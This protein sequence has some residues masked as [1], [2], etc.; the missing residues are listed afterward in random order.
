MNIKHLTST[1]LLCG[2]LS[3]SSTANAER[4]KAKRITK[5]KVVTE[6]VGG[7]IILPVVSIYDGDTI[8]TSLTLPAPLNRV[9]V[10]INGIDTP[11]NPA[12]SYAITGKLG[13][14]KCDKEAMLALA[15]TNYL[16][17]LQAQYGGAM[18]VKNFKYGA[19]AG[20]IVGDVYIGG[21]LISKQ[22]IGLGYAVPYDGKS[23][24]TTNWCN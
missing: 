21:I 11:E 10:R 5:T 23:K 13:R 14:A 12:K 3:I 18:T 20:R 2:L 16:Q 19:Y 24:R 7:G 17:S 8:V 22:M 1:I 4:W 9:S 6:L 15:A